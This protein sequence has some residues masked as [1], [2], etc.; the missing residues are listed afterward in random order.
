VTLL[1][2]SARV[3]LGE[4]PVIATLLGTLQR[5]S[6]TDGDVRASLIVSREA[7][8]T[9][10]AADLEIMTAIAAGPIMIAAD[11]VAMIATIAAAATSVPT[12]AEHRSTEKPLAR[13]RLSVLAA[14]A[15]LQRPPLLRPLL[16][17]PLRLPRPRPRALL[18][19]S[20]L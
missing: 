3:V 14:Q 4:H 8:G 5:L 18:P 19:R 16:R 20:L 2:A 13:G 1:R 15:P 17:H 9:M 6:T 12:T 10:I 7:Q 11:L